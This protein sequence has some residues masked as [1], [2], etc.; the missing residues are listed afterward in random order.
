T[1]SFQAFP[2]LSFPCRPL[3]SYSFSIRLIL[4]SA[5]LSF[6]RTVEGL[7]SR[8]SP[9]SPLVYPPNTDSPTMSCSSSARMANA[10]LTSTACSQSG[11]LSSSFEKK[12]HSAFSR[13]FSCCRHFLL[14][15][16]ARIVKIQLL[17]DSSLRR[18][19][20]CS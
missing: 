10:F 12:V 16:L 2:V 5:R 3:L 8:H 13:S 14:H 20:M 1:V 15:V 6:E 11:A 7:F 18:E 4:A 17:K 9:I 19:P